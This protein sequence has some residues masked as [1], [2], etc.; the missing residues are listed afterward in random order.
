MKL[1]T[2]LHLLVGHAT[3]LDTEVEVLI[4]YDL[5]GPESGTYGSIKSTLVRNGKLFLVEGE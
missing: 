3:D 5:T 1:R 4:L 2:L